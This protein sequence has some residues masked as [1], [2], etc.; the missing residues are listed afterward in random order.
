MFSSSQIIVNKITE[1]K[2]TKLLT[3]SLWLFHWRCMNEYSLKFTKFEEQ[4]KLKTIYFKI[5]NNFFLMGKFESQ[6]S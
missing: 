3:Y 4:Y 2:I 1:I 6:P 5:L